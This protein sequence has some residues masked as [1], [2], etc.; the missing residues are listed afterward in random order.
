MGEARVQTPHMLLVEGSKVEYYS[1]TNN[2]WMP[3][4]VVSVDPETGALTLDVKPN[5]PLDL[6]SQ[7]TK[8]RPL[9]RPQKAELEW[10]R[11]VLREGRLQEEARRLYDK[12]AVPCP[13]EDGAV[14]SA[15]SSR[16][17]LAEGTLALGTDLDAILGTSGSVCKLNWHFEQQN[18]QPMEAETFEEVFWEFLW[19]VQKDFCEALAHESA[20]RHVPAPLRRSSSAPEEVTGPNAYTFG[21]ELGHGTFGVVMT[22]THKASGAVRAVKKISKEE[23]TTDTGH[24]EIEHLL[25]LDHPHVVR[26]YEYYEDAK[27]YY[28]VMDYC[29][30]GDL[31]KMITQHKEQAVWAASVDPVLPGADRS[32]PRI[33]AGLPDAFV[34]KVAQQILS[35]IAH[36]HARGLVHLDLKSANVMLSRS[37]AT[38]PPG[39]DA[40]GSTLARVHESPHVMIIDLGVAQIFRPGDFQRGRACG[41]PATMSPE[42]WKGEITPKA[43]IFSCGVV[44]FEMLTLRLPFACPSPRREALAYWA[45]RP[46]AAWHKVPVGAPEGAVHLCRCMMRVERNRR[47]TAPQCLLNPYLAP[48]SLA[49]SSSNLSPASTEQLLKLAVVPHRSLLQKSLALSIA[50]AWPANQMPTIR[51]L[52]TE[53]DGSRAANTGRLN[54]GAVLAA[55]KSV[56]MGEVEAFNI[57]DGMDLSRDG[58]INWTEF[59]AACV[60]FGSGIFKEDLRRF[61]DGADQDDDGLLSQEDLSRVLAGDHLQS[62]EALGD[63][64]EVLVGRRDPGARVDWKTFLSHFQVPDSCPWPAA[65]AAS[66]SAAGSSGG[67]NS[68]SAQSLLPSCASPGGL[69]SQLTKLKD[70]A[71]SVFGPTP[72][73]SPPEEDLALLASMGFTDREWCTAWLQKHGNSVNYALFVDEYFQELQ[74]H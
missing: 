44:L 39:R 45:E 49:G 37:R 3:A 68:S 19:S 42:V 14:A 67:G 35:A 21:R 51:Q 13:Q 50:R 2:T 27:F 23:H 58:F 55:F 69:F 5:A 17:L 47:P 16:K 41:T 11:R 63:I 65:A 54:K 74:D 9:T 70:R 4:Q 72:V 28:L 66:A 31:L 62:K 12:H 40:R 33:S 56:G 15:N 32:A 43:D 10:V 36:V 6:R 1:A 53:L 7:R 64:F 38:L 26:L 24:P 48:A 57:A 20:V 46:A 61:F 18:D 25:L 73:G 34:E 59:V 29:T 22:A 30:D 60:D 8:L 71:L 52:F